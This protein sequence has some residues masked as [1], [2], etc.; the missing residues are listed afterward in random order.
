M[1]LKPRYSYQISYRLK[2]QLGNKT[3]FCVTDNL[4]N[5]SLGGHLWDQVE[6]WLWSQLW[7]Q[8]IN[9]AKSGLL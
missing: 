1:I 8:L 9:Q 5:F 6:I 4:V 2:K 7:S 3:I